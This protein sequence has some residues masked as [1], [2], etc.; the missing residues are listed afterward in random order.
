MEITSELTPLVIYNKKKKKF[1]KIILINLQDGRLKHSDISNI[2]KAYP[3]ELHDWMLSLTEAFDLTFP[4]PD[5][6]ESIVPCLLPQDEPNV[7][8]L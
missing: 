8:H 7:R 3:P 1:E 6:G 2:W 5:G 4:L